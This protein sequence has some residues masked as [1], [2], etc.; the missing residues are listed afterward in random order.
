MRRGDRSGRNNRNGG[1]G[2]S[3]G[4]TG[5]APLRNG[6]INGADGVSGGITGATRRGGRNGRDGGGDGDFG[7]DFDFGDD[8]DDVD[9]EFEGDAAAQAQQ[10]EIEAQRNGAATNGRDGDENDGARGGD[11]SNERG[12]LMIGAVAAGV[13]VI[14]CL[15]ACCIRRQSAKRGEKLSQVGVENNNN[16]SNNND[17]IVNTGPVPPGFDEGHNAYPVN[18]RPAHSPT[19]VNASGLEVDFTGRV[20]AQTGVPGGK[21]VTTMYPASPQAATAMAGH[22]REVQRWAQQSP[23][24]PDAVAIDV[25][26]VV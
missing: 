13:F 5:G 22:R 25:K 12:M 19:R 2:I 14:A 26:Q 17:A 10:R 20:I 6:R 11:E 7:G 18:G 8:D 3:G 24:R 15:I 23:N 16:N 4:V 9:F 1:D 21:V